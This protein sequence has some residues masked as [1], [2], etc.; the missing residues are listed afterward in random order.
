MSIKNNII[1]ILPADIL[2]R[3]RTSK[4][5]LAKLSLEVFSKSEFLSSVYFSIF[6]NSFRK[7]QKAVLLGRL[8]NINEINHRQGTIYMLRRNIHRI[9]KGLLMKQRRDVFGLSYLPETIKYYEKAA[10]VVGASEENELRWAHDV[11]AS[12]FKGSGSHPEIDKAKRQFQEINYKTNGSPLHSPYK[13][14]LSV[15]SPVSYDQ[16]FELASRRKSVRWYLQ[17]PVPRELIDKAICLAAYSPSACNR[18]PFEF[19]IIENPDLIKS[20]S[21]LASGTKGFYENF[22]VLIAIVGKLR[23]FFSERDRH[24]IYIDSSLA[25]MSLMLALESLGLSSCALN[26]PD[27]PAKE[28]RISKILALESDERVIMLMSLGYPD[29][30][31]MVAYSEKK[32]LSLLRRFHGIHLSENIEV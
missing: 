5:Y 12:Y 1:K 24:L 27:V 25:T 10:T 21:S 26:W 8:N 13:R 20:V 28:K 17:K 14:D 7:E 6:S 23:A 19:H 11:L 18:Q 32:D 29:P 22:P 15:P 4:N 30:D 3:I 9:E 16:L 2:K 31:G